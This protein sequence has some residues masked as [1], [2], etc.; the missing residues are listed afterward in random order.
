M[1]IGRVHALLAIAVIGGG[2]LLTVTARG[3]DAVKAQTDFVESYKQ[4][5]A[6]NYIAAIKATKATVEREPKYYEA[7]LR[8]GYLYNLAGAYNDAEEAYRKALELRPTA[9]E[10]RHGLMLTLMTK[11]QWDAV[12]TEGLATL[13]L[14]EHNYTVT[15][16]IAWAMYNKGDYAG[17]QKYYK[18][19]LELYP[20]D[21]EMKIGL[22]W[23]YLKEGNRREAER[24][25]EDILTVSPGNPRG[26]AGWNQVKSK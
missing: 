17:A 18:R 5:T 21:L 19:L 22:A 15:S 23:S 8:L 2:L 9:L 26:L 25:F 4:E 14:D 11:E 16:R 3:F 7:T 24:L 20:S 10:A 1:E 12:I 13:K 6:R